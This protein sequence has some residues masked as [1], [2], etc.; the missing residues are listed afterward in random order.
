VLGIVVLGEPL[1]LAGRAWGVLIVAG[2]LVIAIGFR[3]A[4]KSS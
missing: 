1:T 4:I 2:V 3:A